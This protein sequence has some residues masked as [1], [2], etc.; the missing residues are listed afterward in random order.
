MCL[1]PWKTTVLQLHPVREDSLN[2][3]IFFESGSE[4]EA[5][6]LVQTQTPLPERCSRFLVFSFSCF[7][8]LVGASLW[9]GRVVYVLRGV[10]LEIFDVLLKYWI[11]LKLHKSDHFFPDL[12]RVDCFFNSMN[13]DKRDIIW[14]DFGNPSYRQDWWRDSG[15]MWIK[16]RKIAQRV[17]FCDSFPLSFGV[18]KWFIY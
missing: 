8:V 13:H 4:D 11:D 15:L 14:D 6:K 17:I 12:C 10:P 3:V 2:S 1:G 5:F 9:P 7:L 18:E 16:A